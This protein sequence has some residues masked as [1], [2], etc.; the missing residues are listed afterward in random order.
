MRW[1]CVISFWLLRPDLNEG[2][3]GGEA[4]ASPPRRNERSGF[5]T[6]GFESSEIPVARALLRQG[7]V[8][9]ACEG[10]PSIALRDGGHFLIILNMYFVYLLRSN[11]DDSYYAGMT[12]DVGKR[13]KDHNSG[14][15]KYSLTK[16]PFELVWYCASTEKK[17]LMILR[18]A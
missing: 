6:E 2:R 11:K 5:K 13:I 12:G 9:Q 1:P 10:V 8:V 18:G 14:S 17:K 3:V 7:F 16:R 15:S 4:T